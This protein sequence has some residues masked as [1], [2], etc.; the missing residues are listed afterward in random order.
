MLCG[1]REDVAAKAMAFHR[2]AGLG[3]PLLQPV[4]QEERQIDE[5]LAAAAIYA[6]APAAAGVEARDGATPAPARTGAPAE[7]L[8]GDAGAPGLADDRRLG[9]AERVRRR[10]GATWE[11]LR[12]FAYTASVIPVL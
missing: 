6:T 9:T 5:L 12:P 4:L 7:T 8:A 1:T 11:I 2:E 10:I 3:L